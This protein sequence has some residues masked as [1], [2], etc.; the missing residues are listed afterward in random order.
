MGDLFSC[1]YDPP[2]EDVTVYEGAP[3]G[4]DWY[5][6][7]IENARADGRMRVASG[8][9]GAYLVYDNPTKRGEY[10]L[11]V[12]HNNR[13]HRFKISRRKSDGKYLLGSGVQSVRVHDTVEEL[14]KYHRGV[15][16]KPIPMACGAI[17]LSRDYVIK[18]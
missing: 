18:E 4:M 6:G 7:R 2:F 3:I 16:G 10:F 17:T 13:T 5:H 14:I 9:N 1:L 11:L 8:V 12:N 15:F